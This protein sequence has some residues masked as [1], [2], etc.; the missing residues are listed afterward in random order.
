[1]D[2][3]TD[4][5]VLLLMRVW[6][7]LPPKCSFHVKLEHVRRSGYLSITFAKLTMIGDLSLFMGYKVENFC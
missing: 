1:M 5:A 3:D 7:H 6:V 4:I 2:F